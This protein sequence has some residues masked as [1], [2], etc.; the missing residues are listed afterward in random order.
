MITIDSK[1]I[2]WIIAFFLFLVIISL[3]NGQKKVTSIFSHWF[4]MIEGFK[5]SSQD[6]YGIL[7]AAIKDR[8]LPN[9]EI[10]RIKFF[11]GGIHSAKREYLRVVRYDHVFDIC[12]APFGNCF[13]FS[14]WLGDS[15]SPLYR[16]IASIPLIGPILLKLFSPETYYAID[17]MLMFQES[18]HSAVLEVLNTYLKSKGM[19]LLSEFERKPIMNKILK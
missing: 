16:I 10:S 1:S 19:R 2:Y 7:E 5:I 9:T 3:A 8:Q 4:Y 18:V 11:E 15:V 14:W 13:F 6:Y 12:A 17:T